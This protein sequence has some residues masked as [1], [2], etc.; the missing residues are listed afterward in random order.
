MRRTRRA[1]RVWREPRGAT[2]P[3]SERSQRALVVPWVR[4]GCGG[5]VVEAPVCSWGEGLATHTQHC[6]LIEPA[7]PSSVLKNCK[8]KMGT[9]S[10]RNDCNYHTSYVCRASYCRVPR[11]C[12]QCAAPLCSRDALRGH[13][14][15]SNWRARGRRKGAT[16]RAYFNSYSRPFRFGVWCATVLHHSQTGGGLYSPSVASSLRSGRPLILKV[17]QSGL[18]YKAQAAGRPQPTDGVESGAS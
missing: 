5:M 15:D 7:L 12:L 1:L 4:C 9:R 11:W 14:V 18:R 2:Q 13:T 3:R 8:K 6:V 17:G 16:L 10:P